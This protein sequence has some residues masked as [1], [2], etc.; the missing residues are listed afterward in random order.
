MRGMST[1][2]RMVK[3]GRRRGMGSGGRL[4]RMFERKR[5]ERML[6]RGVAGRRGDGVCGAMRK[7]T[8]V[9]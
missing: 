4:G 5:R 3:G 8:G 7:E 9:K 6:T 2:L 1:C